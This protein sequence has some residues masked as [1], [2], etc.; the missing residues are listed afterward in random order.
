[1]PVK[2]YATSELLTSSQVADLFEVDRSTVLRW[3]GA[4]RL[5]PYRKRRGKSGSYLFDPDTIGRILKRRHRCKLCN[6]LL[7]FAYLNE[8]ELCDCCIDQLEI[9]DP[10]GEVDPSPAGPSPGVGVGDDVSHSTSS[11]TV[12]HREEK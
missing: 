6:A 11:P 1:M 5:K 2:H 9:P 10:P 12:H 8:N 4:G 7:K 3:V